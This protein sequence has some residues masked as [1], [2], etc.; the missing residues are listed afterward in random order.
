MR[1]R[2]EDLGL[3]RQFDYSENDHDRY[4]GITKFTKLFWSEADSIN[5]LTSAL[6]DEYITDKGIRYTNDR[7]KYYNI[8]KIILCNCCMSHFSGRKH[9]T[10]SLSK[11]Y[12]SKQLERYIP[13]PFSYKIFINILDW[14]VDDENY[15]NLYVAP[16]NPNSK[17]SSIIVSNQTLIN[18]IMNYEIRFQDIKYHER[19][20]NII[21]KKDSFP[22]GY[23]DTEETI[24]RR[25]ILQQYNSQLNTQTISIRNITIIVPINVA[26]I[27][28]NTLSQNGRIF[29]APW[30]NRS[31]EDRSTIKIN[32]R[33]TIEVDIATCSIR[34]A[35]HLNGHNVPDNIDMYRINSYDRELI[36]KI[37]NTMFNVKANSPRQGCSK[38][39]LAFKKD[40]FDNGQICPYPTALIREAADKAYDY[41]RLSINDWLFGGRGLELQHW[42]SMVCFKVIETFLN[43][44]KVVLTIHDSFITTIDDENLLRET[45]INSYREVIGYEPVL[46]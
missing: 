7:I 17:Q 36:K 10:I 4:E 5:D 9:I 11:K 13:I 21:L 42:D 29:G 44:N 39:V 22:I 43:M 28:T 15:L 1:G 14:L 27:Y 38:T 31:K 46:G 12:Y 25:T 3:Q 33:E 35:L 2:L 20:E 26:S 19:V 23:E 34:I 40:Y 37:T 45:I 6:L 41:Y 16:N 30:I 18:Y 32:G 24:Y 8:L